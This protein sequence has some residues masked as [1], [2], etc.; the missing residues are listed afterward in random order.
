MYG[1]SD[2]RRNELGAA[3]KRGA[4]LEWPG[5]YSFSRRTLLHRVMW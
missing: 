2:E 5:A 3:V 1:K 4:F